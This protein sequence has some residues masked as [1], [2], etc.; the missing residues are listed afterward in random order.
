MITVPKFNTN[1]GGINLA[2]NRITKFPTHLPR[3]IVYLDLSENFLDYIE[4]SDLASYPNLQNLT[5]S[6]NILHSIESGSF[7]NSSSL[8]NLD[9]SKNQEL[10]IE[11][12]A[13][14]SRDFRSSTSLRVLNLE[15]TAVYIWGK[16]HHSEI[17]YCR[18]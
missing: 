18:F 12:L 9:I 11:V 10:T 2:N 13:N 8:I 15:K 17:P 5:V 6:N 7:E 4:S 3:N 1:V 16:F 14:I